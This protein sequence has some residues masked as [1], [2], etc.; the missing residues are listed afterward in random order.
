M[1]RWLVSAAAVRKQPASLPDSYKLHHDLLWQFEEP[2]L[3]AEITQLLTPANALPLP[4]EEVLTASAGNLLKQ[5]TMAAAR[6][7]TL[8]HAPLAQLVARNGSLDLDIEVE[9]GHIAALI[10][11]ID[12]PDL[13]SAIAAAY[14]QQAAWY[15]L[16]DD[17]QNA[18]RA[19]L[20]AA[21][22]AAQKLSENA[23]ITLLVR[24]S[25]AILNKPK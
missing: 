21:S 14:R 19:A 6:V 5:P 13:R 9:R 4:G 2:Q 1:G 23:L 12:T 15:A 3:P 17:A 22:V 24:N 20:L 25:L 18:Q 8:L 11:Q 10:D 16:A 7:N